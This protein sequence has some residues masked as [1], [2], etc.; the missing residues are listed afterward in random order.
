MNRHNPF[1]LTG[2]ISP[3]YFCDR[4]NETSRIIDAIKN[5]RN[6]TL[7]SHR[8]IGKT[9]L[10][11]HVF[12]KIQ[13]DK[14][15]S[16]FY[17]DIQDTSTLNEF[18][19]ELAQTVIGKFDSF[20]ERII[21][22]IG[23]VFSGLRPTI[24]YDSL[25]G[26]PKINFEITNFQ[27]ASI[28]LIQIINYLEKQNKHIVVAIDEFQQILN[29]PEKNVEA[30]LRKNI[31]KSKNIV[32]IFAGSH[33]HMMIS[34][35]KNHNRPFYQSSELMDLGKIDFN[36]Y[37]KFIIKKFTEGNKTITDTEV[38]YILEWTKLHTFYKQFLCNKLFS[39]YTNK[40][41]LNTI[42]KTTKEI[43]EENRAVFYNY[44]NL[45]SLNQWKLLKAIAK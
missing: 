13:K 8:R 20:S 4:E 14:K 28:S 11:Y 44:K 10:L 36:K 22:N 2:Y 38:D 3:K 27:E 18:I 40:I 7:F 34:M 42:K 37:K 21:K 43:L 6:L 39:L 1:L 19:K 35:F 5:N 23:K 16:T 24:S 25:T 45:L 15:Y 29:Y 41:T 31:Q 17:L 32:F 12:Y 9:G 26:E 33:K 30:L